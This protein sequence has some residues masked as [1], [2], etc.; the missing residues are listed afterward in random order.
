MSVEKVTPVV[1][2]N[3]MASAVAA[4]SA[5]LGADPTFVDGD[6]WAQFDVGSARIALAG[7]DRASD[8]PGLMIKVA[9]AAS[10]RDDYLAA[11]I[12]AGELTEGSH[13]VRFELEGLDVP[14]TVYSSA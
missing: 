10:A 5:A 2:V 7:T 4:W 14:V 8:Q 13:E 1:P 12:A 11:G 9:N 3:D 6:R